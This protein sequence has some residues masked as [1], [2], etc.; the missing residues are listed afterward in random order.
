MTSFL[1]DQAANLDEERRLEKHFDYRAF[2]ERLAENTF[3]NYDSGKDRIVYQHSEVGRL[4][5]DYPSQW[6]AA[7]NHGWQHCG[8][9]QNNETVS[10]KIEILL[11]RW[12]I[13]L[14]NMIQLISESKITSS[15]SR[16]LN[17]TSRREYHLHLATP[18][19]EI[20]IKKKSMADRHGF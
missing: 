13:R 17:L 11:Y 6:R 5:I 18:H 1:T 12:S 15:L 3:L 4:S 10:P 20:K 19:P 8:D 2:G 16:L 7:S 9:G 14:L